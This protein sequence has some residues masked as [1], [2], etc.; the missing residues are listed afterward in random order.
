MNLNWFESLIYGLISGFTE[1]LPI[2]SH[3]HQQLM[4]HMFG[5]Q[6]RDP[7]RD[8]L[9][10]LTMLF[11]LYTSCRGL[12]ESVRR[13]SHQRSGRRHA[14]QMPRTIPDYRFV[15]DAAM[16]MLVGILV[17]S[18][19]IKVNNS[20][21]LTSVFLLINGVILFISGRVL[22]GN[23]NAR[24]MSLFD[25]ILVG[26]LSAFSAFSGISRIGCATSASITRGADR[27]HALNWA[28]LLSIPALIL[29]AGLDVLNIF[30]IA[31]TIPFWKS[32]FTYILS[33]LGTYV[34]CYYSITFMKFLAVRTGFS[35]FSYYCWGA[36]LFSFLIYLTVA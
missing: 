28:L 25:S 4:L 31:D 17:L 20:L 1:F 18:Y 22:Q 34:G 27:Q 5:G 24:S 30:T 15:K 16:P 29:L 8:L 21:L 2:S 14:A 11:A 35:I 32:F 36:S 3:G 9:V 19:I 23:K 10:H 13:N 26:I 6:G 33:I 12:I 7:V